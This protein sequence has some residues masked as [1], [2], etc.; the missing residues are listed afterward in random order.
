MSEE[1][2]NPA[3]LNEYPEMN[4]AMHSSAEAPAVMAPAVDLIEKIQKE[5]PLENE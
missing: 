4:E 5:Y 2:I 3:P 1:N